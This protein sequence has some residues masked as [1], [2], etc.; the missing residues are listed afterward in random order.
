MAMG[1]GV[2]GAAWTRACLLVSMPYVRIYVRNIAA[3]K[4]DRVELTGRRRL[5]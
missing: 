1:S 4:L 3:L 5:C 2:A